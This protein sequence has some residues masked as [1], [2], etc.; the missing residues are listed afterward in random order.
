MGEGEYV[1]LGCG[2][3]FHGDCVDMWLEKRSTCPVC[4]KMV[5]NELLLGFMG[6]SRVTASCGAE[7]TE[8]SFAFARRL[9]ALSRHRSTLTFSDEE[10]R[11]VRHKRK[12]LRRPGSEKYRE[13]V[14]FS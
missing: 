12:L 14:I 8:R 3:A 11:L 10:V 7:L 1:Q 2:H 4:R 5:S 6:R 13:H 9:S